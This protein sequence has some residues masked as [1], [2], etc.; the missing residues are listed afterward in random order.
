ML[1]GLFSCG[2]VAGWFTGT[3]REPM[4]PTIVP[5][6]FGLSSVLVVWRGVPAWFGCA[7]TVVFC[8]AFIFG[9]DL[10]ENIDQPVTVH[11]LL[12]ESKTTIDG[13]VFDAL[14]EWMVV[15]CEKPLTN[16]Q[17][18]SIHYGTGLRIVRDAAM[19]DA[20]KVAALRDAAGRLLAQ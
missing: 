9:V 10:G 13:P 1:V 19:S 18:T 3:S 14:A 6:I 16:E 8:I 2:W 4:S 17:R 20:E 5:L 7:A 11:E 12:R 15:L